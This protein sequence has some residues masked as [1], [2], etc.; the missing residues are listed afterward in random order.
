MRDTFGSYHPSLNFLYFL[1]VIGFGMFLMHPIF[2]S[3]S[4]VGSLSYA[5]YL[6]G[7]KAIGKQL[8]YSIPLC[9][10]VGV[11]NPLFNHE[12]ITILTYI[13]DNPLTLESIYYGI[14]M[15]VLFMNI[16]LWFKCYSYVMTS[17]KLIYLLG[18]KLPTLALIFSMTLRFVPLFK[19]QFKKVMRAQEGIGNS[20]RKKNILARIKWAMKVLSI[21]VTWIL[22][23]AIDTADSMNSR[24]YGLKGRSSF[25]LYFFQRRD[26]KLLIGLVLLVGSVLTGVL[27]GQTY[28]RYF[29]SVKLQPTTVQSIAVYIAYGVLCILP[30]GLQMVEDIK[31][32][33]LK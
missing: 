33:Y 3:I 17:D 1:A 19:K 32:H 12:G 28:M 29:P 9:I 6:E 23:N 24:G 4:L 16:I 31:W 27:N 22:E 15:A 30:L 20:S 18:R 14:A 7:T 21:M 11:I 8:L 2:L 13:G 5:I 10:L 26:A 25:S